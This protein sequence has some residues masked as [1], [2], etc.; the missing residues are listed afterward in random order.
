PEDSRVVLKIYNVRGQ[1]VVSLMDA[2]LQAGYYTATWNARD[3]R[4]VEV[5][6]GIYFCTMQAGEFSQTMKMVLIR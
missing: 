6:A 4:G 1:E 3:S 5:S 2:D